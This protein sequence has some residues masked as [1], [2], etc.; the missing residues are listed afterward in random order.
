MVFIG[1][2]RAGASAPPG[3]E[4]LEPARHYRPGQPL[5]TVGD[6]L[7]DDDGDALL[8]GP[9][10]GAL[11]DFQRGLGVPERERPPGQIVVLQVDD[12]KCLASPYDDASERPQDR[13]SLVSRCAGGSGVRPLPGPVSRGAM[14]PSS[15]S[16]TCRSTRDPEG[17]RPRGGLRLQAIPQT[18]RVFQL[19]IEST[20][21]IHRNCRRE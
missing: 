19:A 14:K 6:V 4:G 12:E 1:V 18:G 5:R 16:R 3:R 17:R 11:H 7:D 8:P 20:G 13:C 15:P 2:S 21:P 9:R 10:D